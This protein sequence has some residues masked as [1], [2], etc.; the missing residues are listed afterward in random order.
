[1]I[2]TT[3]R[4]PSPRA[5][6]PMLQPLHHSPCCI[7]SFDHPFNSAFARTAALLI[8]RIRIRQNT[9]SFESPS[10]LFQGPGLNTNII[11]SAH[12]PIQHHALIPR[13]PPPPILP[14]NPPSTQSLRINIPRIRLK[15]I[16]HNG[17]AH[18]PTHTPIHRALPPLLLVLFARL[19]AEQPARWRVVVRFV[20]AGAWGGGVCEG[21]DAGAGEW[22]WAKGADSG[23]GCAA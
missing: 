22:E 20:A 11:S 1:M 2:I 10:R 15:C 5:P 3:A 16:S 14:P 17:H 18:R 9:L 19:D 21:L 4:A 23:C 13:P 6:C 7:Y 8:L 12:I